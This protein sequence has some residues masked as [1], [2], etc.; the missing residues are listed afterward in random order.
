MTSLSSRCENCGA[1]WEGDD[2]RITGNLRV[3]H[4]EQEGTWGVQLSNLKDRVWV[5]KIMREEFN[6]SMNDARTFVKTNNDVLKVGTKAE[7][8]YVQDKLKFYQ[9]NVSIT[10]VYVKLEN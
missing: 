1:A 9:V 8:Y 2:G 10:Q 7:S 3:M 5:L 4:L 6:F